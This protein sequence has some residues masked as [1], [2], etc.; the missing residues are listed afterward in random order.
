MFFEEENHRR[1]GRVMSSR[2]K[3]RELSGEKDDESLKDMKIILKK[4]LNNEF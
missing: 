1:E 2:T 3:F 4:H